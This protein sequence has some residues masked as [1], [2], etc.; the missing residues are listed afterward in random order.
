MTCPLI[1]GNGAH[2]TTIFCPPSNDV[3]FESRLAFPPDNRVDSSVKNRVDFPSNNRVEFPS[4]TIFRPEIESV[5]SQKSSR[6]S[7]KSA[8]IFHPSFSAYPQTHKTRNVALL[9]MC[10]EG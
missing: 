4:N 6:F 3:S 2:E 10:T 8:L 9:C 5:F 1:A 7:P